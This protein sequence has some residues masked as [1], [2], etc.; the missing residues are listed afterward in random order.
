MMRTRR[1]RHICR[2]RR[3]FTLL[4]IM[5]VVGVLAVILAITIPSFLRSR[6]VANEASAAAT[7]RN[8][9]TLES[10]WRQNDV[11]RNSISDY[12]TADIS[13][14]YRIELTPDGSNTAVA[15]IDAAVTAADDNKEAAGAATAGAVIPD[16]AQ[17]AASL[18]AFTRNSPRSGYFYRAQIIDNSTVPAT[19]YRADPDGNGQTWTN[20]MG[21]GF[22]ARPDVY[23]TNGVSTIIINQAG[24][25]YQQDF[26][27]NLAANAQ[28]W[29]GANPTSA[30][31]RVIQ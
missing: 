15:M 9:V 8:I 11:D 18:L 27:S 26:G 17:P 13:G 10:T 19:A 12:W 7:L 16:T 31:W 2:D 4:E 1:L 5:I 14:F 24:V 23:N 3:A 30:G 21:Y 22:Q 29:P 6:V 25:T 28:N 20:T